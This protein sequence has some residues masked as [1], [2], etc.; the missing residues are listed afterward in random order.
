MKKVKSIASYVRLIRNFKNKEKQN[1]IKVGAE[2]HKCTLGCSLKHSKAWS[3]V[4]L[5]YLLLKV[6][7]FLDYVVAQTG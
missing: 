4:E 6:P 7:F 3:R 1:S 5:F 2:Q